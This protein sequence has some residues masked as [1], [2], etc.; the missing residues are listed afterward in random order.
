M[1]TKLK[2]ALAVGSLLAM[3]AVTA[4][5]Y[6]SEHRSNTRSGGLQYVSDDDSTSV[7]EPASLAL[8]GLGLAGAAFARRRKDK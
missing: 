5:A 3:T 7:P 8:M 2:M 1:I 6:E 4:Q